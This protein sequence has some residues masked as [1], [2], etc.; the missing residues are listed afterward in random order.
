MSYMTLAKMVRD[1]DLIE[2]I[3]A[4]AAS[5]R[6]ENPD[7]VARAN[8][9]EFVIT[10]GWAAKFAASTNSKPGSDE[11]AITDEMILSAVQK[12]TQEEAT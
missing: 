10:E 2:R 3:T 4:C 7:S 1:P 12:S 6:L 5:L 8:M 9:W 11:K